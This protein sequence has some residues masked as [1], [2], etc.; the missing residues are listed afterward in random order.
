MP[1]RYYS[2]A[3]VSEMCQVGTRRVDKQ[4]CRGCLSS[5]VA[6]ICPTTV[7]HPGLW[8]KLFMSQ[9]VENTKKRLSCLEQQAP[10]ATA[11]NKINRVSQ[12]MLC[13]RK[14]AFMKQ[15]Q[16]RFF[17]T[18]SLFTL[19]K[20]DRGWVAPITSNLTAGYRV[21]PPT[22]CLLEKNC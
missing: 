9:A 15:P 10:D 1:S 5:L 22:C 14:T 12:P 8:E 19:L 21:S 18:G 13:G 17:W 4:K 11:M 20:H 6:A 7:V 16:A 2:P 3:I